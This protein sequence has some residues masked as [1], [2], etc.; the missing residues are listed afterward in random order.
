MYFIKFKTKY[1]FVRNQTNKKIKKTNNKIRN[2]Q[3][4]KKKKLYLYT[5]GFRF[6]EIVFK[7]LKSV[8]NKSNIFKYNHN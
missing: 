2:L 1:L 3:I 8:T 7:W 4:Q 6:K 5:L